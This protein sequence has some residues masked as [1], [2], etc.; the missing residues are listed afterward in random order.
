MD[1]N[2]NTWSR[3]RNLILAFYIRVKNYHKL[4]AL[5]S[6]YLFS[7]VLW[8]RYLSGPSGFCTEHFTVLEDLGKNPLTSSFRLLAEYLQPIFPDG[9]R[10]GEALYS[11]RPLI[12]PLT[13]HPHFQTSNGI[14]SPCYLKSFSSF[15]F[16]FPF[17]PSSSLSSSAINQRACSDSKGLCD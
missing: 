15:F 4:V 10:P 11:W 1:T 2:R 7:F 9:Y 17:V 14:W 13:G 3:N 6:V 5:N 8:V 16:S 12:F